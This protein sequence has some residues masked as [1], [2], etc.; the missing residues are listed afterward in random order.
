MLWS[1]EISCS[2]MMMIQM[3]TEDSFRDNHH[4][5]LRT[6]CVPAQKFTLSCCLGGN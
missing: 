1:N 2:K 3:S 5:F 6:L 4:E